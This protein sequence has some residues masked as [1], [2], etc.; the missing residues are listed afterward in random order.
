MSIIFQIANL[1]RNLPSGTVTIAH[2]RSYLLDG[3]FRAD[4]YGSIS[5]PSKDPEDPT[6]IAFE[7]LTE[8][9]VIDWVKEVLGEDQLAVMLTNMESEIEAKK[10]P[11]SAYGKPW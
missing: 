4:N 2:W 7:D 5:L 3:E 10:N 1:E 6:F 11:T 8:E 9:Q